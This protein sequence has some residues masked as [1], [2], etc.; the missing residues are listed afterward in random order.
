[1]D[2]YVSFK[3]IPKLME[4]YAIGS[5][6]NSV[7]SSAYLKAFQEASIMCG[8]G[9]RLAA[10]EAVPAATVDQNNSVINSLFYNIW[11]TLSDKE[12]DKELKPRALHPCCLDT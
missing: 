12:L 9:H 11:L 4:I 1:M 3:I 7:Y 2:G 8:R 6:L 5:Q 10:E